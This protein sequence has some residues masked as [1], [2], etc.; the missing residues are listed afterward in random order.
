MSVKE[1]MERV[2]EIIAVLD[3]D[4][5]DREEILSNETDIYA[6]MD[7]AMR[8]E[9]E[10]DVQ[11]TAMKELSSLYKE[12]EKTITKRN[13]KM[14]ELLMAMMVAAKEKSYKGTF[15]TVTVKPTPPKVIITDESKLTGE[16]LIVKETPDKKAIKAAFDDKIN[17]EGAILSNGGETIAIRR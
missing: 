8:K 14:R 5:P 7:W 2:Q 12:R 6:L 17:V 11:I 13:N 9:A 4:D 15:G 1:Q 10:L 3:E 16:Y